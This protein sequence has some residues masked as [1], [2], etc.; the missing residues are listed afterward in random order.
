MSSSLL[1]ASV[2][3]LTADSVK[4]RRVVVSPVVALGTATTLNAGSASAGTFL[5]GVATGA[6]TILTTAARTGSLIFVSPA[7]GTAAAAA[8]VAGYA[9][10]IVNGVSFNLNTGVAAGLYNWWIVSPS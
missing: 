5:E 7:N 3:T 6:R 9:D 10:T 1:A 2:D 8:A 4:G